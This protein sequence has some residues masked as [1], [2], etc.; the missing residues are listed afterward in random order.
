MTLDHIALMP[1]L[2]A[3]WRQVLLT[4]IAIVGVVAG[5][6]YALPPRYE[7]KATIVADVGGNDPIRGN[8][9]FK[10]AGAVSTHI[11]TQ[12]DI[13]KSEEVA[14][15]ALRK[16][17]LHEQR[18]WHE[19]WREDTEGQSDF[20]AWLAAKLL[21]RLA[22]LPSRDSNVLTLSYTSPDPEFSTGVVNAFV[23][24]YIDTTLRMQVGP[25]RQFNAFFAERAK[26]LR[27][28]LEQA[29]ARL[30]AYE[31]EH[32][33]VVAENDDADVENRRLA[34]LTSQLVTLQDELTYTANRRRQ[35]SESPSSMEELRKD[36]EVMALTGELAR[37]EARLTELRSSF[38][39]KYPAVTEAKEA[40]KTLRQR[41]DSAMRRAAPSF[42]SPL[43]VNQARLSEMQKSIERQRATVLE[44][45]SKRDAAAA[46][47]RDV[48]NAQKAYDAVLDRASQT[49]LEG[50]NTTQSNIS[51]LKTGTPPQASPLLLVNVSVAIVVGLLFGILKALLAEAR[52]RRLRRFDDVSRFLKQPLLLALP[53][54]NA[55]PSWAASR[56]I[57][58]HQRLV[59]AKP[60]MILSR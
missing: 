23:Q 53:D 50:A 18:E 24:S 35:A 16:L 59:S 55:R 13:I 57:E 54:G 8:N 34:D 47:L 9:V 56:S 41:I 36:P 37:Q 10:P 29:K 4:W 30:S 44:R 22:V 6:T 45:K 60:R 31:K 28:A 1:T 46:L 17:G 51:I 2:R 12:V 26:P 40:A 14:I 7:A 43:K 5:V 48:Q 19:K 39:E 38:G 32:K 42:D 25:A 33:I 21:R 15:G 58:A 27:E 52:D 49:A 20:Q 3:R 11:A